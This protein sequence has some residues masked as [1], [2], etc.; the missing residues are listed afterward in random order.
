MPV[1]VKAEKDYPTHPAGLYQAVCVDVVDLGLVDVTYNGKTRQQAK[2]RVVWQSE[3]KRDDDRP[4][5]LSRRYTAS[6]SE[7]ASLRKD[8][9]SWRGRAFTPEELDGFDVETLLGVNAFLTI[10]H[11]ERDGKTY[12]NVASVA[13][14]KKGTPRMAVLDY[15]REKDRPEKNG[16]VAHGDGPAI[17]DDDVPF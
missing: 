14:L 7:K 1:I 3:E 4:F 16:E 2:V 5:L 17:T 9:E 15:V 13:P 6:L 8:L 11:A 12:A 10:L